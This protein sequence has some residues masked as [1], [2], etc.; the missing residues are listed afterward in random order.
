MEWINHVSIGNWVANQ[1]IVPPG[2]LSSGGGISGPNLLH[3]SIE[4]CLAWS[5][6]EKGYAQ[7]IIRL[8]VDG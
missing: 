5:A 3:A 1:F 4:S 7:M 6:T 8:A 2:Y